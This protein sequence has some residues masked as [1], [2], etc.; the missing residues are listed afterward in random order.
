M[1]MKQVYSRQR[2]LVPRVPIRAEPM[3][4]FQVVRLGLPRGSGARAQVAGRVGGGCKDQR[5]AERRCGAGRWS[6]VSLLPL[7]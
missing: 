1:P 5:R 7:Q 3:E 2:R 4:L 6:R